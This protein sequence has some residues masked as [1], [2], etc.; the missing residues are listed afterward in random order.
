MT[1]QN[2]VK[3]KLAQMMNLLNAF[4]WE[5]SIFREFYPP[6][7]IVVH[8]F[9]V[10]FENYAPLAITIYDMREQFFS[11]STRKVLENRISLIYL[12]HEMP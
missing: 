11:E 9:C 4:N 12:F 10:Q 5:K 1:K 7:K 2:Q 3:I 8:E 6:D